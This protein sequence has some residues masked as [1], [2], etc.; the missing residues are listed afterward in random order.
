V[1]TLWLRFD[2]RDEDG[3]DSD[4]GPGVGF[5]AMLH[6]EQCF[7]V[8]DVTFVWHPRCWHSDVWNSRAT[9]FC[10]GIMSSRK[11]TQLYEINVK[12]LWKV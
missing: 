2:S 6:S 11:G 3:R 1:L 7:G 5:I 12:N 9:I 4:C 10:R 8:C